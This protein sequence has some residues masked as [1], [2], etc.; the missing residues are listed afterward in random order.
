MYCLDGVEL[1]ISAMYEIDPVSMYFFIC[2]WKD[3]T[4][5]G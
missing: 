4:L 5:K 2:A 1:I 3:T